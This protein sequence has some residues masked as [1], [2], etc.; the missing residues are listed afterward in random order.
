VN[1]T[2]LRKFTGVHVAMVAC[3]DSGGK[4]SPE[5]AKK[6]TRYLIDRGVQGLYV[7]GGTGE[8]V[9][10]SVTERMQLLEAVAGENRGQLTVTAHVGAA[11]TED[12]VRLAKY[13][14]QIGCDAV[15]AIPPFYYSYTE[16]AV[17]AHWHAIMDSTPLPFI[18]YY[19]PG[20][21]GFTMTPRFLR[22]LVRHDRMLGMKM[23][24]FDTYELQQFKAIGGERFVVF[25]GP[26]QQYLAGRIMGADAGIGGTYGAMP[27]LFVQMEREYA[28][29]RLAE[30]QRWQT[31]VNEIITEIRSIGLFAAV[32][33]IIRLRGV[34]C[35]QPRRPL[36][37][38]KPEDVGRVERLYTMIMR[39]AAECEP[40]RIKGGFHG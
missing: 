5:A 27:E 23:T 17:R 32:K 13:A 2:D 10:Q 20:A 28:S 31:I 34:D 25:N 30:A 36:P 24:T 38:L 6:L 3:Y 40:V 33:E 16:E 7:G 19:I 26:D 14:E 12:S 18:A 9:L 37:P 8:G 35:G 11:T 29:G 39:Y 15:S 4:V 22:E 21:T 1:S